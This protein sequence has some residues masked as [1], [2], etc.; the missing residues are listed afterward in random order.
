MNNNSD[1][2]TSNNRKRFLLGII[3]FVIGFIS[4]LAIPVV[5]HSSL[6]VTL[7]GV[8][9]GI[10]AFGFPE[11]MILI[12]GAIMGKENLNTLKGQIKTWIKPLAPP[13]FVSKKRFIF[14][15]SLFVLCL[16]ESLIHVHWDGIVDVYKDFYFSYMIFWNLLFLFS[17]YVLGGDFF[18]RLIG[19][20]KYHKA[21]HNNETE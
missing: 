7:K 19:L 21:N 1:D 6:N 16:L 2:L 17:L 20:F 8:L 5:I 9:S 14:G 11:F 10:L 12:S 18:N 4:P 13:M 15:I 3:V